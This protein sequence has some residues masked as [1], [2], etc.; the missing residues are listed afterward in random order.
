MKTILNIIRIAMIILIVATAITGL[1]GS[2]VAVPVG[3]V[4]VAVML[5]YGIGAALCRFI[6]YS[7]ACNWAGTHFPSN[8]PSFDGCSQHSECRKCGAE[9]MLDSQGNWF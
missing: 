1:A 4:C 7:W 2:K 8:K 5:F 9:I 3:V 6:P